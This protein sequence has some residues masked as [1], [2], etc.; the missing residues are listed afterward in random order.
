LLLVA[1][2]RGGPVLVKRIASHSREAI[3]AALAGCIDP[4]ATIITD[5]LPAYAHLVDTWPHLT[6]CH[7]RREFARTDAVSGLRVHVNTAEA[8]DGFFRR[9]ITGVFHRISAEHLE[10]Y[11]T[12]VAWRWN[13]RFENFLDRLAHLLAC[14]AAAL[15]YRALIVWRR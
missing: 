2:Q 10:R 5:G 7:S 14:S 3:D 6:V 8:F 4:T 15:P 9:T 12:E 1:S 11:A 13:H